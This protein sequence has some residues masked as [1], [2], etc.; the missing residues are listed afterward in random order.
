MEVAMD[1]ELRGRGVDTLDSF[2]THAERRL[3]FAFDKFS[4]RTS[5]ALVRVEDVNGP[6]GGADKRCTIQVELIPSGSILAEATSPRLYTA[7]DRAAE[8]AARAV[9]RRLERGHAP[10][11]TPRQR[12]LRSLGDAEAEPTSPASAGD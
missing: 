9:Q 12:S 8:R 11:R 2:R 4:G 10:R 3:Q 6:R 1:L 7:F 5:R